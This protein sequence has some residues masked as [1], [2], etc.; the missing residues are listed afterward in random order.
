MDF[1]TCYIT[2]G[3]VVFLMCVVLGA[4]NV[5][6]MYDKWTGNITREFWAYF[7]VGP[8]CSLISM[9]LGLLIGG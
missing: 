2:T 5:K 6:N 9:L 3:M 1:S 7:I 4:A 8:T